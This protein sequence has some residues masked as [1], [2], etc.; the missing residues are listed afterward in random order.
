MQHVT[1]FGANGVYAGWPANHGAWQW[2]DEF[3]C[4]FI[5]GRHH[6][7]GMHNVAGRLEKVMAR[8]VDGGESWAVEVPNVDFNAKM[9]APAPAFDLKDSII[10]VSGGYDHGGEKCAKQGG[11]YLSSDRGRTWTG[12]FSFDGIEFSD[13]QKNTSRTCV[14][15]G[16]VFLS[17]A[18]DRHW[19]SDF[20]FCVTHDGQKF[21]GKSIVLD[22]DARAVMP[23]AAKVKNRIVVALRRRGSRRPG[24]W[25]DSVF[26]DDGGE[27]WSAPLHVAE[28]GKDNGNPPALV[29][30]NGKLYCAYANRSQH[31]IE[32]MASEDGAYSWKAHALLRKGGAP[33]IGYPR[34]FKRSDGQLCCV[35][36]WTDEFAMPQRIEATIFEA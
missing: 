33:D 13:K 22:D 26:S 10:R 9:T 11:F 19:G 14:L 12:A 7:G 16:L 31:A 8:S 18:N 21:V 1:V 28:T 30:S 3:L 27:T 17:A 2:G 34:L 23:A 36:Y 29:E 15:G 25:I 5:R 6:L 4:G 32:V 35:Y 20:A 24:G